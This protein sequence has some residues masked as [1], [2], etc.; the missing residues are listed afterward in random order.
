MELRWRAF[1]RVPWMWL[2][3]ERIYMRMHPVTAVRPG[4]LFA[5][6]RTGS[7]VEL[8]L[9]SRALARRRREPGYTTFQTLRHL[10]G[11]LMELATKIRRGELGYVSEIKGTSLMGEAGGGLGFCSR[12][13]PGKLAHVLE[14]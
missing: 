8:H 3:W 1:R 11:D 4:S 7:I 9:D 10:R 2:A 6:R 14:A 12:P 13:L 5:Y